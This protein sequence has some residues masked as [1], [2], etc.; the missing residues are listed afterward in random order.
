MKK[1]LIAWIG[2]TDL[3]SSISAGKDGLGPIANA[4][5]ARSFDHASLLNNYPPEE[6]T[7]Y[8]GWLKSR[9]SVP[10]TVHTSALTSPTNL[11]EI[12]EAA[13]AVV[14]QCLEE[15]G[16]DVKLTF[17][18]SRVPQLWQLYGFCLLRP[19]TRQS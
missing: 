9:S 19:A 13:V 10:I 6:I 17:H 18:L 4:L 8:L 3:K 15:Y 12:Y 11:G 16:R 2:R 1:I 7:M 14:E 5:D